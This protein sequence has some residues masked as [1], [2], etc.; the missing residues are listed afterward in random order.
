MQAVFHTLF[1]FGKRSCTTLSL[2]V[3]GFRNNC[4]AVSEIMSAVHSA[5][6]LEGG[7]K[8]VYAKLGEKRRSACQSSI[9]IHTGT[10]LAMPTFSGSLAL[11]G[12]GIEF[13]L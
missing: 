4:H 8:C 12:D 13:T 7:R 1:F 9:P 3:T 5:T 11:V 10:D 2:L 6:H